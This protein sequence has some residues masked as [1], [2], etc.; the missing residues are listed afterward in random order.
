MLKLAGEVIEGQLADHRVE[1]DAHLA[2]LFQKLITGQY[3]LG[4]YVGGAH[5]T[6]ALTAVRI[7]AYPF[8]VPGP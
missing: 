3:Y 6:T 8:L 5:T 7:H 1:L 2:G 4:G